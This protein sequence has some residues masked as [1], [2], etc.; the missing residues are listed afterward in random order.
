MGRSGH[1]NRDL[2]AL[3]EL[4]KEITVDAYGDDEKFWAFRQAFEDNVA[5]PADG[6]VIG[7]PVSV[8]AID[9]DGDERHGLTMKCCRKD[10]TQYLIAASDV[11]FPA[12]SDGANHLA[13]W[14]VPLA[15]GT[16]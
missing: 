8:V 13:A 2:A 7:E 4:I 15:P 14:V 1:S 9:Y 6:F 3:E 10:G 16:F 5:L 12:G 11:L